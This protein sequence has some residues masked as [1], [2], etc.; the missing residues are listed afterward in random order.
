[1]EQVVTSF[2]SDSGGQLILSDDLMTLNRTFFWLPCSQRTTVMCRMWAY[3]ES[4]DTFRGHL[5]VKCLLSTLV[6][7]STLVKYR[8]DCPCGAGAPRTD[9]L[10]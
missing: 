6:P 1:M 9:P 3:A 7:L 8:I 2:S 4:E 5:A 10:G